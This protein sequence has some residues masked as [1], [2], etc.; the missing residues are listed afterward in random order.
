MC[1]SWTCFFLFVP[2]HKPA[3]WVC[4]K[5]TCNLWVS[6][7][8]ENKQLK[9]IWVVLYL[10]CIYI[11]PN[12]ILAYLVVP[13]HI[14]TPLYTVFNVLFHIPVHHSIISNT[15]QCIKLY[16]LQIHCTVLCLI[17]LNGLFIISDWFHMR[18]ASLVFRCM[19]CL[20]YCWWAAG[21]TK[22]KKEKEAAIRT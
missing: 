10:Y 18:R 12:R 21:Q 11:E 8:A 4:N 19:S 13:H 7:L 17:A 1:I 15:L 3:Q 16:Y 2:M 9:F 22:H 20:N 6:G 14:V 5:L